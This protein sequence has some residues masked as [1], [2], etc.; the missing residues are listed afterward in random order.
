MQKGVVEMKEP[1][2]QV[3]KRTPGRSQVRRASGT[4]AGRMIR[5]PFTR[6]LLFNSQLPLCSRETFAFE[7][8]FC[9]GAARR[10]RGKTRRRRRRGK[11]G[12]F[13]GETGRERAQWGHGRPVPFFVSQS[14]FCDDDARLLWPVLVDHLRSENRD[15]TRNTGEG[16]SKSAG[17]FIEASMST[18]F[19]A[20]SLKVEFFCRGRRSE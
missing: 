18:Y 20:G 8:A 7:R 4:S 14:P 16:K 19:G 3:E 13:E 12:F 2:Y 9:S 17:T 6:A 1:E 15:A 11:T 5:R 10:R